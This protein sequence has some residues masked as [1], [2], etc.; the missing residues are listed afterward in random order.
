MK[1]KIRH[2]TTYTYDRPVFLEPHLIRLC[3]RSDP[4]QRLLS[5]DFTVTPEPA[6][7]AHNID[8]DNNPFHLTWFNELTAEFTIE[9]CSLIETLKT[10]PFDSYLTCGDSLPL[11]LSEVETTLLAPCLDSY[12]LIGPGDAELIKALCREVEA[13]GGGTVLSTL[14]ALNHYL[15][16]YVEKTT[17]HDFGLQP[18]GTTLMTARGA[19]RDTALVF[20]AACRSWGIPA[21]FVS[22]CHEGDPDESE[23]ELHAWAEV[24]LPGFGWLGYDPTHGLAV[25]D[26]HVSYAASAIPEQAAPV[27][28]TFRGT[29]A[30]AAMEH[31]VEMSAED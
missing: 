30:A 29:G 17:R 21:R 11:L 20:M 9:S 10:N 28:G 27:S 13:Q 12:S 4:R 3:P 15:F 26:R 7:A 19:C 31:R 8:A 22:G 2:S 5:F 24:Y 1:F 6:G 16:E 14:Q 25:A 18:V 23:G